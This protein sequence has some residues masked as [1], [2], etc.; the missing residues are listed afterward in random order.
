MQDYQSMYIDIYNKFRGRGKAGQERN[1]E[2]NR[3]R[4]ELGKPG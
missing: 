3:L 1:N 2:D 4:I